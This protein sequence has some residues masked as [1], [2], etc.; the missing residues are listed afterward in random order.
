MFGA[1]WR[2]CIFKI[3]FVLLLLD[4]QKR[5]ATHKNHGLGWLL[6]TNLID[7]EALTNAILTRKESQLEWMCFYLK[8]R[9]FL[10]KRTFQV[11][12]RAE[13]QWQ[14]VAKRSTAPPS[15]TGARRPTPPHRSALCVPKERRSSALQEV[16]VLHDVLCLYGRPYLQELSA[17]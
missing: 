8:R 14:L 10:S 5:T 2:G 13:P 12:V 7:A 4:D 9:V 11:P 16:P 15:C 17:K 6:D 1:S 3:C